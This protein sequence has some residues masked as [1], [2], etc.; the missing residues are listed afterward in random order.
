MLGTFQFSFGHFSASDD[1]VWLVWQSTDRFS[2]VFLLASINITQCKEE[3]GQNNGNT[4]GQQF[5][6]CEGK[7]DGHE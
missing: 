2:V 4:H 3:E 6:S 1:K 7:I 5:E